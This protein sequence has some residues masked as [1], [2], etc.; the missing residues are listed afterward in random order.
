MC[1]RSVIG[2]E[3]PGGLAASLLHLL[4]VHPRAV[5]RVF[6]AFCVVATVL[7]AAR[8]VTDAFAAPRKTV[9]LTLPWP[10]TTR[11]YQLGDGNVPYLCDEWKFKGGRQIVQVC[12]LAGNVAAVAGSR[13][14]GGARPASAPSAG[15]RA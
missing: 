14:T 1:V 11:G 7:L 6:L 2:R 15:Y 8:A 4:P 10:P 12:E 3:L 5:I 9:I 13:P